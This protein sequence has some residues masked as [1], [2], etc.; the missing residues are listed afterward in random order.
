MQ[1]FGKEKEEIKVVERRGPELAPKPG[2]H[3]VIVQQLQ[4]KVRICNIFFTLM[5]IIKHTDVYE[6]AF[7]WNTY[8]AMFSESFFHS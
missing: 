4:I 2:L 3:T 7:P 5:F 8:L 6:L 1:Q